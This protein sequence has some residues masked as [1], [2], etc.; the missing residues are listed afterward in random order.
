[1]SITTKREAEQLAARYLSD[2]SVGRRKI[3]VEV[4]A[5]RHEGNYWYILVT[6]KQSITDTLRYFETL[7]KIETRIHRETGEDLLFVPA[8]A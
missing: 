7:A 5:D 1:M 6:P 2:L 8:A 3:D 4:R